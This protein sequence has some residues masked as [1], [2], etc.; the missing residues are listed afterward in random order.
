VTAARTAKRT[1]GTSPSKL[2]DQVLRARVREPV[3]FPD[4]SERRALKLSAV[5]HYTARAHFELW[6]KRMGTPDFSERAGIFT[7]LYYVDFETSD[8]ELEPRA[9]LQVRGETQLA[10]TLDADGV[11]DHLVREGRHVVSRRDNGDE[12]LVARA[13]LINVFTRF[14]ADPA[15]RRVTELPGYLGISGV[16]ARVIELPTLQQLLPAERPPDGIESDVRVWHYGQTDP[17]RH[18]TSMEYLRM[19]ECYVAE[20]LHRR[21]YD[22]RQLYFAA[23]RMVYRKPCFRGESYRRIAWL[24]T[25][26]PLVVAGAFLKGGDPPDARPAVAVELTLRQHPDEPGTV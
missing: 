26:Q 23:A 24:R 12:R 25:E 5:P 8:I 14:D 22:M 3:H 10:K 15:R 4:L 9:M 18:V 2:I 11:V 13:H 1:A 21:G 20:V 17:N 6:H 16:P 19:M 7:P